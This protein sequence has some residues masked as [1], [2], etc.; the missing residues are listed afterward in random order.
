M[1]R[2]GDKGHI[3]DLEPVFN[4]LCVLGSVSS[5]GGGVSTWRED[6]VFLRGME[7]ACSGV[8]RGVYVGVSAGISV[9]IFESVGMIVCGCFLRVHTLGGGTWMGRGPQT[10][11]APPF[12]APGACLVDPRTLRTRR[13][14]LPSVHPSARPPR[15]RAGRRPL[16]CGP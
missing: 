8:C 1:M 4:P 14:P 5:G 2:E 7:G 10:L 11:P 16:S 9:S 3:G 6:G 15:P 13:P 12:H